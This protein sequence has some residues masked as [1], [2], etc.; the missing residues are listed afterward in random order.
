MLAAGDWSAIGV[1]A[2]IG[3]FSHTNDLDA[4]EIFLAALPFWIG[5]WRCGLPPCG[6]SSFVCAARLFR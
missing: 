6:Q 4:A 3:H 5:A 1:F 2:A